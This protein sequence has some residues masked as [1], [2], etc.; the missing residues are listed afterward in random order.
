MSV[1]VVGAGISGHGAARLARRRGME[2]VVYDRD[3]G[4][5]S[6]LAEEGFRTRGGEWTTD[7][8]QGAE[9][10]V[11]SPGVAEHSSPVQD[12][13]AA[14][15]DVWSEL[16][17]ASRHTDL[18]IVAVTGTNGKT[19]TTTLVS[20]MLTRSGQKA[21]TAG[22]IGTALS[23]VVDEP[24]EVLVV[25]A[26]SFQLRFI[27]SFRP[28][29]AVVL[30]VA[31]D[32]LDWHRSIAAYRE[33]KA[34]ICENQR[35]DDLL[36]FGADDQGA[37]LI[38]SRARARTR[39]VSGRHFPKEGAGVE[40]GHLHLGDLALPIGVL[41]VSDPAYLVDLAAAGVAALEAGADLA[42]VETALLAFRPGAHRRAVV[43]EW[44][45][46]L[47]VDDSKA[48]NPHAAIASI[49]SFPSVVLL[50]GG[51]NKGLDLTGMV[52]QPNLKAVVALGEARDEI[53]E[54][55][56][57]QSVAADSIEEAVALAFGL[58]DPGDTVLL[59]PGC[60]SFDMFA[61]YAARGEAFGSAV[62]SREGA[63]WPR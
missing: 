33:S 46:I 57:V 59:A 39:P 36:V 3:P 37:T 15:L 30:N 42:A 63:A 2:A 7:A 35:D 24:W 8:L 54:A 58:A 49:R 56:L 29:I 28:N 44:Q 16:E 60:A 25:E 40:E 19:T 21:A 5:L 17:F 62:R 27:E 9:L 41:A 23:H 20:D 43:G 52:R 45:G 55:A 48:T 11:L 10:V 13:I 14:G 53:V 50:A 61:S 1:L 51:R 6:D 34:R 4:A 18:P 26:S 12:A 31:E 22:N 32:H 38:A 47:W